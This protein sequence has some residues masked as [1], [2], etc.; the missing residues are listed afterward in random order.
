MENFTVAIIKPT[1]I[2]FEHENI[3]EQIQSFVELKEVS[4][5]TMMELVVE[6]INLDT[7]LMGDTTMCYEDADCVYQLCHLNMEENGGKND[8]NDLNSIGS[9]L[10]L[11]SCAV[12]G[13]AVLICSEIKENNTCKPKSLSLNNIKD[14]LLKKL[15][16]TGLKVNVNGSLEEF[17]FYKDPLEK[18]SVEEVNNYQWMECPLIKFNLIAF[19][20]VEPSPNIVNKMMTKLVGKH[21]IYGE[22]I[23]VSKSSEN[24]FLDINRSLFIKL[25]KISEG[26]LDSR[27]LTEDE[28]NDN[29][30]VNGLPTV[31]NRYCILKK[32]LL[33]YKCICSY[34]QEIVPTSEAVLCGGCYRARYHN[35]ECQ[36][37]HWETHN[38]DCLYNKTNMNQF[39]KKKSDIV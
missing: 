22:C 24:E 16:H 35:K 11:G 27:N 28:K 34:C 33:N 12:F 1:Q 29:V 23:L 4:M 6:T 14:I 21:R 19:V 32:R 7:K 5:D 39:L 17:T 2:V 13:K 9:T 18:M 25:L 30:K 10:A 20:Q 31:M 8:I 3:L 26:P 36:S 15:V 37:N 38:Q